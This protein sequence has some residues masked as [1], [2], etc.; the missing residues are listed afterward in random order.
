MTSDANESG[1]DLQR[2]FLLRRMTAGAALGLASGGTVL[3]QGLP[4]PASPPAPSEAPRP[5]AGP[6]PKYVALMTSLS[7]WNRWGPDDQM[8]AVNL[9]TPAVRKR[10]LALVKEGVS[11]S[12]GLDAQLTKAVDNPQPIVRDVYHAGKGQPVSRSRGGYTGDH[13]NIQYHNYAQTHMNALSHYLFDQK[14]YNGYSQDMVTVEDGALRNSILAFKDGITTRGVLFDIP[15]LK[16]KDWLEPGEA[17]M[18]ADLDA[19]EKKTG[20]KARAGDML[21]VRTG[22]WARRDKLGP[23]E[24]NTGL[25]GLHLDCGQ[26]IKD[27]D[28]AVLGNDGDVDSKPAGSGLQQLL[29][30]AMGVP[31]IDEMGLELIGAECER[32]KRWEFLVTATPWRVPGGTGSFINPIAMF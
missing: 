7:N 23:W 18:P 5:Q 13:V 24:I 1:I 25:A 31:P 9:I 12:L 22:R 26:W 8:G 2:R 16:G 14:M 17:I 6:D 29:I 19:W 11:I 4:A 32:R 3:A 20:I 15:R 27:R 30:I 21:I 28:I 10:A